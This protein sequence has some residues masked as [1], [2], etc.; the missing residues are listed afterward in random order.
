MTKQP[1]QKS[2]TLKQDT[3]SCKLYQSINH[4]LIFFCVNAE[5][6]IT[7]LWCNTNYCR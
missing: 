3:D 7:C 2:A 5:T 6:H 1:Q 4:V